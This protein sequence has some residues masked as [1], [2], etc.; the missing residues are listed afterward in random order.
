M[1]K[2]FGLIKTTGIILA[3]SGYDMSS[4][5]DEALA[6]KDYVDDKAST[7]G[8]SGTRR[9]SFTANGTSSFQVGT[10]A[11]TAGKSYYV[12]RVLV[13]VTTA[14]T[15]A[16]ELVVSDGTNTLMATTDA[17]LSE[18][19]LYIVDLGFESATTGGATITA[20]IQNSGASAS[21]SVGACIVTAEYKQI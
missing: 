2:V 19:G 1:F 16:D 5:A 17:D 4:A 8:S 7:S 14:F 12:S 21:P 10:M 13:K 11:N 20:T 15:G 18:G 3:P 6:T 9:V